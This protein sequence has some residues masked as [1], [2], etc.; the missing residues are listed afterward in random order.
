MM[1]N[2]PDPDKMK[3]IAEAMVQ[4]INDA[5]D[6]APP[7][8]Q[9]QFEKLRKIFNQAA[10]KARKMEAEGLVQDPRMAMMQLAPIMMQMKPLTDEIRRVAAQDPEAMAHIEKMRENLQDLMQEA[11]S[12]IMPGGMGMPPFSKRPPPS[13]PQ[14]PS[15]P[16]P[17][18]S[19]RH[20]LD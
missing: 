11:M 3:Q 15:G 14:K 16:R 8:I 13:T 12:G 2:M 20:K 6:T 19:G 4:I 5:A 1:P 7:S 17:P 18:K 10:E 9:P